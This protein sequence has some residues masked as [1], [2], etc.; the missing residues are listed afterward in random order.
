M[1]RRIIFNQHSYRQLPSPRSLTTE[2]RA[3]I[4]FI[5]QQ[6]RDLPERD[7]LLKQLDYLSVSIECMT[8]P[9]IIFAGIAPDYRTSLAHT[10]AR[11]FGAYDRAAVAFEP[12]GINLLLHRV[13]GR[14]AELELYRNDGGAIERLPSIESL[15]VFPDRKAMSNRSGRGTQSRLRRRAT[16]GLGA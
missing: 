2:E 6:Y 14:F 3:I 13:D 9:T 8:C 10:R 4:A 15:V 1:G 7:E 11:P 5:L 16:C 12:N